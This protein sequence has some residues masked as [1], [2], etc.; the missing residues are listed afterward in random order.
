MRRPVGRDGAGRARAQEID[1]PEPTRPPPA[2]Q[3][4]FCAACGV[5][6]SPPTIKA[7]QNAGVR[8][9]IGVLH[10]KFAL[11]CSP[12]KTTLALDRAAGRRARP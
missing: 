2:P 8:L 4:Q 1:K 6:G 5:H 10:R 12:C 11:L 3:G 9:T 7:T